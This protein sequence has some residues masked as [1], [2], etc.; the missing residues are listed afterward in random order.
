MSASVSNTYSN[1]YHNITHHFTNNS[2]VI[3]SSKS[4]NNGEKCC[5]VVRISL[6]I[7]CNGCRSVDSDHRWSYHSYHGHNKLVCKFQSVYKEHNGYISPTVVYM[8]DLRYDHI[9]NCRV[10]DVHDAWCVETHTHTLK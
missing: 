10:R 5:R 3:L 8:V 6:S 9:P 7:V 2:L 1:A 4:A